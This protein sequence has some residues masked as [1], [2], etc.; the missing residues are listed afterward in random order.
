MVP[1]PLGKEYGDGHM[2]LLGNV[3]HVLH[4]NTM[5]H[6][7]AAIHRVERYHWVKTKYSGWALG[8]IE[9]R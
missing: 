4:K 1:N 7:S 8:G 6:R 3:Y 5:G 2:G 9:L